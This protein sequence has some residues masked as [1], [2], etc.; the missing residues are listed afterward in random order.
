MR[1]LGFFI[2]LGIVLCAGLLRS[3]TVYL[4]D[5]STVKGTLKKVAADTLVFETT[6]GA[7]IKIPKNKIVR[8][9]F[10]DDAPAQAA[11][12]A[13]GA[14]NES[15]E[16]GSLMV[17]FEKVTFTSRI[18]VKRNRDREGHERENVIEAA[19]LVAGKKVYSVL[20]S[21]TDK[22][23]AEGPETTLRNDMELESFKIGI[24]PGLYQGT[25]E[26]TTPYAKEYADRFDPGPLD[27]VLVLDNLLIEPGQTLVVRVGIK[28][29][30]LG[31][32]K[33]GMV[34]L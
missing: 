10:V 22:V 23:I 15:A 17:I 32:R 4:K 33:S 14:G 5:G 3:E 20:D 2:L 29:K 11:V 1:R 28:K 27:E 9:D 12:G 7:A 8:I 19:L 18:K 16:P 30:M 25:L 31:L 6:F 24:P 21:T 26:V 34:K 13:I